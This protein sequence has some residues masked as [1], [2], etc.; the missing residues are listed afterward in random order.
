MEMDTPRHGI[1]FDEVAAAAV[2]VQNDGQPV[3]ID[4]VRAAL[5]GGSPATIQKHLAEWRA[6]T[7]APVEAPQPQMPEA[8][9]AALGDWAKQFA[10]QSGSG[11]REALAQAESDM[12]TLRQAGEELENELSDTTVERDRA[13]A[14]ASDRGEE[15]TRLEAE[16]RHARQIA[17]DALVGKAKDQLAIDGKDAQLAD[18]R[19]QLERNVAG[20]AA[21]SDARLAAEMELVGATT[22]RDNFAAEV[23]E[24]RTQLEALRAERTTLRADLDALRS[25]RR[26]G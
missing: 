14:E 15:I 19:T 20:T 18:L 7:A 21:Q 9:V 8:L 4:A 10:E 26:T 3:T 24:V 6:S 1:T 2:N 5:G 17:A 11:P 22:A 13:R 23:K 12:E 25:G 16:L